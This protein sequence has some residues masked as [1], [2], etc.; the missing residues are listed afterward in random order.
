MSIFFQQTAQ[1][2]IAKHIDRD[3]CKIDNTKYGNN[4]IHGKIVWKNF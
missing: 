3:F 4:I 2:M 1:V